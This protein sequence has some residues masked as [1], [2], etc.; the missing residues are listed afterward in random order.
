MAWQ[1]LSI[2]R[3]L[4]IDL[5]GPHKKSPPRGLRKPQNENP[6]NHLWLDQP[7]FSLHR[8]KTKPAI[9]CTLRCNKINL[10]RYYIKP[11]TFLLP[12]PGADTQSG[13][14]LLKSSWFFIPPP[15]PLNP[16]FQ[17]P[18]GKES[19]PF[20]ANPFL[21]FPTI[22]A[23]AS[24]HRIK[25]YLYLL[26]DCS[27]SGGGHGK[28]IQYSVDKSFSGRQFRSLQQRPPIQPTNERTNGND[29]AMVSIWCDF[30][31]CDKVPKIL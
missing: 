8:G 24:S 21:P 14:T 1:F 17:R 9:L 28:P 26:V 4:T 12:L 15:P 31:D 6:V 27:S 22:F 3:N 5:A 29:D 19:K 18:I 20:G 7:T 30:G 11:A 25:K 13:P 2:W 16:R 23:P 10:W